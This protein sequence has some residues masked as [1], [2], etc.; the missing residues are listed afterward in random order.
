MKASIHESIR[1]SFSFFEELSS[2]FP[3]FPP[4]L[5]EPLDLS[6]LERSS[7]GAKRGSNER[8]DAS[9]AESN[10]RSLAHEASPPPLSVSLSLLFFFSCSRKFRGGGSFQMAH[11]KPSSSRRSSG[12]VAGR[13]PAFPLLSAAAMALLLLL[14]LARSQFVTA[15]ESAN[16]KSSSSGGC[17]LP[18]DVDDVPAT[19]GGLVTAADGTKQELT[20]SASALGKLSLSGRLA[21]A[22]PSGSSSSSACPSDGKSLLEALPGAKLVSVEGATGLRISPNPVKAK[23]RGTEAF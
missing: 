9:F 5:F 22:L 17:I 2:L 14:A 4:L 12:G 8:E 7:W 21:L 18:F 6:E 16:A 23:V 3:S 1:A 20:L 11:P 10:E 19:A 15:Q 13:R